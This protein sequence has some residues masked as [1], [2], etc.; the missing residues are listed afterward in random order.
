MMAVISV[1]R[2]TVASMPNSLRPPPRWPPAS[3]TWDIPDQAPGS[4][5]AR[6]KDQGRGP[7]ED[8]SRPFPRSCLDPCSILSLINK[9]STPAG[10]KPTPGRTI[11]TIFCR[12]RQ[13]VAAAEECRGHHPACG[14]FPGNG[15]PPLLPAMLATVSG[16]R[17]KRK[18]AAR[19]CRREDHLASNIPGGGIMSSKLRITASF[20]PVRRH[21][22][23]RPPRGGLLECSSP[24]RI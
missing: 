22:G 7:G 6:R 3:H 20:P 13:T 18:R 5:S 16:W 21:H 2:W 10:K 4:T 12:C 15:P 23:G 9:F 14:R 24:P 19:R 1:T 11:L 17:Q 8:V